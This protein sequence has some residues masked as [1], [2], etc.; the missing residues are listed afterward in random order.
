M[1]SQLYLARII[2]YYLPQ[3]AVQSVQHK[4]PRVSTAPIRRRKQPFKSP[5]KWSY[6]KRK[7]AQHKQQRRDCFF[8]TDRHMTDD[9]C[10]E[11]D[12]ENCHV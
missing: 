8:R 11:I 3:G 7:K 10:K 12:P 5:L 9:I 1:S 2:K 4:T 6:R